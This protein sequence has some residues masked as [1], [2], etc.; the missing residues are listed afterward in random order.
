MSLKKLFIVLL[1]A[2]ALVVTGCGEEKGADGAAGAQGEQGLPGDPGTDYEAST[3]ESCEI[4]HGEGR[5]MDVDAVEGVHAPAPSEATT[6]FIPTVTGVTINTGE[7]ITVNIHV[8]DEA[9]TG[10]T[11]LVGSGLRLTLAQLKPGA[12]TGDSS[13][14]DNYFTTSNTSTAVGSPGYGTSATQATSKN[15]DSATGATFSDDGNGDYTYTI[16]TSGTATVFTG[17]AANTNLHRIAL[18]VSGG[19]SNGAFNFDPSAA[20]LDT[21]ITV[22]EPNPKEVVTISACNACHDADG[23]GNGLAMHGGGRRDLEYCVTCHNPATTDEDSLNTLNLMS[24]VHKIHRG[25]DLPSVGLGEPYEIWGYQDH[26]FDYTLGATPQDVTN[27]AKCH[28]GA[29]AANWN[30]VVNKETCTSCHDNVKFDASAGASCTVDNS[31]YCDHS[32]GT[33]AN[34]AGCTTCHADDSGTATAKIS[35]KHRWAQREAVAEDFAFVINS[36]T[37]SSATGVV[38]MKYKVTKGGAAHDLS[39][40][41]GSVNLKVGW[42]NVGEAD[43]TN[44]GSGATNN[45]PASAISASLKPTNTDVTDNFATDG[46]YTIN[47]TLPAEAQAAGTVILIMDGRP[48]FE[49]VTGEGKQN[50]PVTS[51]STEIAINDST[52]QARRV[53]ANLTKCKGCHDRVT[54]HGQNRNNNI[55]VCTTCHNSANTDIAVRPA[56]PADAVDGKVEEPIDFKNMIHRIHAGRD[57]AAVGVTIYGHLSSVHTFA[58]EFPPGTPLNSCEVCHDA[59][60]YTLPLASGIQ[61]TTVTSGDKVDQTD[62]LNISPTAAVCSACHDKVASKA[63]MTQNGAAFALPESRIEY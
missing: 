30:T 46:T 7:T 38:T 11:G 42:K 26:Y 45:Q 36:A 59:G 21:A 16:N 9:G 8:E 15:V 24:L 55:K 49:V 51:A 5:L 53:N 25:K 61:G 32:G 58:G 23:D 47:Y 14:W 57:T 2:S 33:Q 35:D 20:T 41:T 43:Y 48:S 63:H 34:N 62:D 13:Y 4:C 22:S 56:D 40:E 17:I 28:Q 29:D 18:Q 44:P 12:A 31:V 3:T 27:C 39:T 52:V 37:Y 54:L 50:I 10:K 1:A 60:Q 6:R 19:V